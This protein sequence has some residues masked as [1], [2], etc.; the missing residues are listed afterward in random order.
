MERATVNF[1]LVNKLGRSKYSS[2][3]LKYCC[4]KG[5]DSSQTKF[6]LEINLSKS[7]KHYLKFNTWCCHYKGYLT[8]LFKDYADSDGWRNIKELFTSNSVSFEKQEVTTS[9]LPKSIPYYLSTDVNSYL[10]DIRN[11]HDLILQERK[12]LFCYTESELLYNHIIFPYYENGILIG[13]SSQNFETKKYKNHRDL[14]FIPYKEFLNLNYPLIITEGIYDCFS[15]PNSIPMLGTS[16]SKELLKFGKD[17][18]IILALDN[19]VSL[20]LKKEIADA[21]YFY[22][23]KLVAIF[24]LKDYKDLNEWRIKDKEGLKIELKIIFDL[25][26]A[27]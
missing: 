23:A 9:E 2:Q 11:L 18:K 24:G 6:N 12:V 7:S 19:D 25:L 22:G 13:Y 10:K 8:R 4:P 16:P 5:C 1:Y 15:V 27:A 20:E 21:F 17:K 26:N 3:G 14:N